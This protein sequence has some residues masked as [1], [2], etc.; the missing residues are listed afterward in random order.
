MV[1]GV[2]LVKAQI[3]IAQGARI[4]TVDER[5]AGAGADRH[6]RSRHA[7]PGHD[8]GSGERLH[9]GL[10][11]DH[12]LSQPGG[13]RRAARC[14]HGLRRR[15]HH[16]L[17]RFAAGQ[18]H[19][20]GAD[21]GGVQRAHAPRA[22]GVPGARRHHEPAFPGS[23]GHASGLRRRQLHH[24]V[25]RPDAGAVPVAAAAR[26]CH[27][28]AAV[29]SATSS[30]TAIRRSPGVAAWAALPE[31]RLPKMR[32]RRH[33]PAAARSSRSVARAG[34]PT[35]CSRRRRCWSPTRRC[36]TP[37]SRCWPRASARTT[38]QRIAPYY[39]GLLPDLFSVECWGGATFDVAMRFLKE[40]PWER[41]AAFREAMPN[42]LLQMLLRSANAV[43][44]TNYPD[45]V[46]RYFVQQAAQRGHRRL[47]RVRLAQLGRQHA[48][49]DGRR[50]RQRQ[51]LRSGHLLHRQPQRSA[52]DQVRPQVLRRHWR[53]SWS[54][55]AR[56]CSA[57][58]TWRGC[59]SR[60]RPTT[61]CAR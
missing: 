45:N 15:V 38:W 6:F 40:C 34:W 27:A 20:L 23:G 21:R 1:T 60:A 37:T 42:L 39:A 9:P 3:R 52:P 35:G 61:S 33:R 11:P 36:A 5:S 43:G 14:R 49:R 59:A 30:S 41:L 19:R 12:G 7:V 47:P 50:D 57:S 2:D 18:G 53:R 58:R 55:P 32:C 10:R 22:V 54:A 51:G 29:S 56:T 8:R 48:R 31:P 28:A 17:L 24:Q 46:V 44:Y 25:H 26:P 4:G 16:A 13:F